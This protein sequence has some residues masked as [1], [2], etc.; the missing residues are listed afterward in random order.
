MERLDTKEK[1][2]DLFSVEKN[3]F[4]TLLT[5]LINII[6]RK[7]PIPMLSNFK[8]I[9]N[10]DIGA[11]KFIATDLEISICETIRTK[12][13]ENI[14][15][16]LPAL[17]IFNI[18]KRLPKDTSSKLYLHNNLLYL[19]NRINKKTDNR[20]FST[21][22]L[23]YSNTDKYPTLEEPNKIPLIEIKGKDL[24][25]LIEKTRLSIS[26]DPARYNLSGLNLVLEDNILSSCSTDTHRLSFAKVKLEKKY[27]SRFDIIIPKKA[28]LELFKIVSD[29]EILSLSANTGYGGSLTKIYIQ[30]HN[31]EIVSK[32]IS[33]IFP[34]CKSAI[35]NSHQIKV[36]INK[37]K[38]LDS[39]NRISVIFDSNSRKST[40]ISILNNTEIEISAR[41][42]V[43]ISARESVDVKKIEY[44]NEGEISYDNSAPHHNFA[45]R[46]NC[47]YMIDALNCIDQNQEEIELLFIADSKPIVIKNYRSASEEENASSNNLYVMMPLVD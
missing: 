47:L 13:I 22:S 5:H 27:E 1:K 42:S 36:V 45:I 20:V 40:E 41:S 32:L 29:E 30:S 34:N 9:L 24:R 23:P 35:P 19:E 46:F 7:S 6:P 10:K 43:S 44:E 4:A 15:L 26:N 33:G 39:L 11:I 14:E 18:I 3:D 12:V 17:S 2:I 31:K 28:V 25:F 37:E 38:L 8:V 16:M 21:F